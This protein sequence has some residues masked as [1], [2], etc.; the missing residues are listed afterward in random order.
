MGDEDVRDTHAANEGVVKPLK[1]WTQIPPY[2]PG[3]RCWLEQTTAPQTTE[4]L[5]NIDSKWANNPALSGKIFVDNNTYFTTILQEDKLPVVIATERLKEYMPYNRSI[6][7]EENTVY[8]NDFAHRQDL[9]ANIKAAKLMGEKL[10]KDIYIRA[11]VEGG[12]ATGYKNPELG[13]GSPS[14][15]GDLKTYGGKTSFYNFVQNAVKAAN[16]QGAKYAVLDIGKRE[17]YEYDLKHALRGAMNEKN[18]NVKRVIVIH[19]REVSEFTREKIA[20]KTFVNPRK[21]KE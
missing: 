12:I 21:E 14:I 10:E 2:D 9:E 4:G 7:V 6:K 18:R 3:C 8:I 11:H 1:E 17:A 13:I 16:K 19:K 15:K 20:S 5:K